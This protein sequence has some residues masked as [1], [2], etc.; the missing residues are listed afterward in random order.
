MKARSRLFRSKA[1]AGRKVDLVIRNRDSD[2]RA[3]IYDVATRTE[4]VL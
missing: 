2:Y 1:F 4:V 3:E